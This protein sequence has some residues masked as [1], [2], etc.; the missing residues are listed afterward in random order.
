ML[1]ALLVK[2]EIEALLVRLGI[3]AA[4]VDRE[5]CFVVL[6]ARSDVSDPVDDEAMP[7]AT[8]R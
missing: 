2:P 4:S 7:L 3:E 8:V 1:E 6:F 5:D